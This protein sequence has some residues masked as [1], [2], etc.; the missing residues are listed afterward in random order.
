VLIRHEPHG[1]DELHGADGA[2]GADGRQTGGRPV[3]RRDRQRVSQRERRTVCLSTQAGCAMG[4]SFCATGA[5]GFRRQLSLGEVLLQALLARR[6]A[7]A[8]GAELTHVVF[9]G[10]G[11]PLANYSVT[12]AALQ[13]LSDPEA[14]G[15][16]PRRLTV[17]TVGLPAQIR[18]LAADH[19]QVNLAV[20]LHA[21]D[22]ALRR[23]L[24]PLPPAA[25]AAGASK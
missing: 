2:D 1:A 6:W 22:A 15:L 7:R 23:A 24:V 13:R 9:M 20:S 16:S 3:G 5:Q 25:P 11:E 21:A 19:P 4:C 17:S 18:R 12:S 14:F 8:Q 10:M